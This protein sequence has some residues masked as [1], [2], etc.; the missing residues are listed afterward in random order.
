MRKPLGMWLEEARNHL[1]FADAALAHSIAMGAY[2]LP[3]PFHKDPA[4]RMLVATAR[5]LNC[6]L[7]T[8]DE[9][10]LQCPDVQSLDARE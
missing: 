7:M 3:G 2:D 5:H 9:R 10:I 8:A 6:T 4:D 1:G